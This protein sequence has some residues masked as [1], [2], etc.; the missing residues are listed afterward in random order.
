MRPGFPEG[1]DWWATHAPIDSDSYQTIIGEDHLKFPFFGAEHNSP[2]LKN[3]L[4]SLAKVNYK[5]NRWRTNFILFLWESYWPHWTS[6][7]YSSASSIKLTKQFKGLVA[8]ELYVGMGQSLLLPTGGGNVNLQVFTC[9]F[10]AMRANVKYCFWGVCLLLR[11]TRLH[12]PK[13][14]NTRNDPQTCSLQ[15]FADLP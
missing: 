7:G 14:A 2:Y 3:I 15:M 4:T 6:T 5:R 13:N 1:P 12:H 10:I 8:K 9:L 11:Q